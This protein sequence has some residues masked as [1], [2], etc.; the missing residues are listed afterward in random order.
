MCKLGL[1][2]SVA[3]IKSVYVA[4]FLPKTSAQSNY[5]INTSFPKT[6]SL[7]FRQKKEAETAPL[8]ILSKD[9]VNT[10]LAGNDIQT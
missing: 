1:P 3:F 7:F 9:Y 4:I 6:F 5:F 8:K 2:Q 10:V